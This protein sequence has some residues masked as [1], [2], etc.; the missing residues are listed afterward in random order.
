MIKQNQGLYLNGHGYLHAVKFHDNQWYAEICRIELMCGKPQGCEALWLNCDVVDT[1]VE[2]LPAYVKLLQQGLT[3]RLHF[4]AQYHGVVALYSGLTDNDP[5]QMVT[6][7]ATL[8]E[9]ASFTLG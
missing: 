1:L 3:I 2:K 7:K 8:V 4:K 5:A 6:F 9:I